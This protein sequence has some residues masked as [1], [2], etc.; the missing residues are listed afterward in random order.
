MEL[1]YYWNYLEEF[2]LTMIFTF[3][4]DEENIY[5]ESTDDYD[6]SDIIGSKNVIK[7]GLRTKAT[8][9]NTIDYEKYLHQLSSNYEKYI[10]TEINRVY[11][12]K[13]YKANCINSLKKILDLFNS[14]EDII[15]KKGK[16]RFY[17]CD[18]EGKAELNPSPSLGGEYESLYKP[19]LMAQY[20]NL[21]SLMEFVF[22]EFDTS[23][24]E[25]IIEKVTS[26]HSFKYVKYSRDTT[27]LPKLYDSLVKLGFIESNKYKD[28][29][30]IFSG[31]L[32]TEK[33]NWKKHKNY[34][35]YFIREISRLN[36]IDD[37]DHFIVASKCFLV[38]GKVITNIELKSNNSRPAKAKLIDDAIELL[39]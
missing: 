38:E 11:D 25:P 19:F 29:E 28:F 22:H 35:N 12:R 2:G 8:Y 10:C 18:P 6:Q 15:V 30:K 20:N 26:S 37:C 14:K 3:V 1:D 39:K 34:F 16:C 23:P 31:Q 9:D 4:S 7:C 21:S 24:V 27:R 33:V 13:Q 36:L 5:A 32:I 17:L